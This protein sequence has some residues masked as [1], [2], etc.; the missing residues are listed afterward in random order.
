MA[1]LSL[2]TTL[3]LPHPP[4]P[5][6]QALLRRL[7]ERLLARGGPGQSCAQQLRRL[8]P[9]NPAYQREGHHSNPA[10]TRRR[11]E[12]GAATAAPAAAPRGD[13]YPARVFLSAWMV[14]RYAQ[15]SPQST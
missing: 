2:M 8:F 1:F 9:S 12:V 10:A 15:M 6:C 14:T 3:P 11:L 13:R 5:P 4:P 7:E